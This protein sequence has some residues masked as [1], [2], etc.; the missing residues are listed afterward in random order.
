MFNPCH[1]TDLFYIPPENIRKPGCFQGVKE[2]T[3]GVKK[4]KQVLKTNKIRVRKPSLD[5]FFLSFTRYSSHTFLITVYE[6]LL[7]GK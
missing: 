3:S 5:V 1:A 4:V 6:C 2:E 7:P